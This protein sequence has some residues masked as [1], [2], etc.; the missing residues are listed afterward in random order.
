VVRCVGVESL[1][2]DALWALIVSHLSPGQ[3]A[4]VSVAD[5]AGAGPATLEL[6]HDGGRLVVRPAPAGP[7]G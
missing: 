6:A 7:Q 1:V 2:S 5:P 4:E 3:R